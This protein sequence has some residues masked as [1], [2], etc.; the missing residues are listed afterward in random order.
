MEKL[1]VEN[2]LKIYLIAQNID[3]LKGRYLS[4]AV[5]IASS[6]EQ[7]LLRLFDYMSAMEDVI[8]EPERL[9]VMEVGVLTKRPIP[10]GLGITQQHLRNTELLALE[11]G[12]DFEM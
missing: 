7:A 11:I 3:H 5:I 8:C 9:K 10:E 1:K 12:E 2:F 6:E 4:T